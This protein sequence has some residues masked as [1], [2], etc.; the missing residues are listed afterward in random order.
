M[1][2]A[3]I[4]A[5]LVFE[6]RFLK[7]CKFVW[8]RSIFSEVLWVR[9]LLCIKD[10]AWLLLSAEIFCL[11]HALLTPLVIQKSK[12]FENFT[13][14][15]KNRAVRVSEILLSRTTCLREIKTYLNLGGPAGSWGHPGA[16][17]RSLWQGEINKEL[18]FLNVLFIW[19]QAL[20]YVMHFEY[21]LEI[22]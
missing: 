6:Q 13:F 11:T 1:V 16:W 21:L 5:K 2:L 18:V 4:R 17:R 14:F 12:I 10:A 19:R 22:L 15:L 9:T 7:I 3:G 8:P 20:I